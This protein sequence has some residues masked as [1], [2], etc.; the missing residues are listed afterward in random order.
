[1]STSSLSVVV[2]VVVVVDDSI[3]DRQSDSGSL[4]AHATTPNP[5]LLRLP[6]PTA[7]LESSRQQLPVR[8]C[9]LLRRARI[10]GRG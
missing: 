4:S 9:A 6:P 8:D 10:A 5:S 7:G 1:M 2:V 3:I